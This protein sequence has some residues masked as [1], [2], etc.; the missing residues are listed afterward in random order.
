MLRR[1]HQLSEFEPG[2]NGDNL[3]LQNTNM[4]NTLK[5]DFN[6]FR[7]SGLTMA[8][9]FGHNIIIAKRQHGE[10]FNI[11]RN[12]QLTYDQV[13]LW[14]KWSGNTFI[15]SVIDVILVGHGIPRTNQ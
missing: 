5:T 9:H 14:Y 11:D 7:Q 1:G 8:E 13:I 12:V 15:A 4:I 10:K 2:L 6:T 3:V